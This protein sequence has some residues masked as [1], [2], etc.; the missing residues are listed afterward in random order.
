MKKITLL[1]ICVL[2]FGTAIS[3]ITLTHSL[4]P[5]SIETGITC[6]NDDPSGINS[7]RVFDLAEFGVT[8][9]FL[10]ESVQWGASSLINAVNYE[11]TLVLH[12]LEGDITNNGF[13][14]EIASETVFVQEADAGELITT[15]FVATV[16]AGS[17]L[18]FE[19]RYNDDGVTLPAAGGNEAGSNEV[20]DFPPNSML[21]SKCNTKAVISMD[22]CMTCLSCG[23]SKCG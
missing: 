10:T 19:V 14:T 18:V 4:D 15:P 17:V 20:G 2:S 1:L 8:D 12:T 11:V 7:W 13:L 21:C 9:N 5:L 16:P 6:S 23:D 22:G 3:Q